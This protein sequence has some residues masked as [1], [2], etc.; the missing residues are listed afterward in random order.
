MTR[1]ILFPF[2]PAVP[3]KFFFGFF[4]VF[5]LACMYA[6]GGFA[7]SL[8]YFHLPNEPSGIVALVSFICTFVSAYAD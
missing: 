8:F 1:I 6:A 4:G 7:L 2:I 3:M 5:F